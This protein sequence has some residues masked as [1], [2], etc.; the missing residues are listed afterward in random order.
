MTHIRTIS[1]GQ[2]ACPECRGVPLPIDGEMVC[3]QCG[4]V[5]GLSPYCP[6][7]AVGTPIDISDE[8]QKEPSG[9]SPDLPYLAGTR[10]RRLNTSNVI[11]RGLTQKNRTEARAFG[12]RM[13]GALSLSRVQLSTALML[14]D[15]VKAKSRDRHRMCDLLGASLIIASRRIR[16][17][18]HIT[19]AKVVDALNLMGFKTKPRNI[20]Q[21]LSQFK[22]HGLYAGCESP[23]EHL[24]DIFSKLTFAPAGPYASRREILSE[25]TIARQLS[26]EFLSHANGQRLVS[27][28]R[29]RAAC[30]IY[31]GFKSTK[32]S[33]GGRG[34][35]VSF[36]KVARASG[37]A[38]YT[39][40]DNFERHFSRIMPKGNQ[41]MIGS[42]D[43][44]LDPLVGDRYC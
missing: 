28:P 42:S 31:A 38:E 33:S 8:H 10:E 40:R 32:D 19:I 1:E 7:E 3:S 22:E 11:S 15:K 35:R 29:S 44:R 37:L 21:A 12:D 18:R 27:N 13:C 14:L 36:C 30:S 43:P 23:E 2:N 4:L 5:V 41:K 16:A 25:L 39:I 26:L 9:S 34:L 24:E 20:L 17:R 6:E